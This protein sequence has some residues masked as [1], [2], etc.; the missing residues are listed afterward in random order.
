[1]ITDA[2]KSIVE[3]EDASAA[4]IKKAEAKRSEIISNA[5]IQAD[6][7]RKMG[8]EKVRKYLS[9]QNSQ[10]MQQAHDAAAR[11]EAEIC[12]KIDDEIKQNQQNAQ[13]A[14]DFVV[15]KLN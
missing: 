4:E 3:A 14:T 13:K 9:E 11:E 10:S 15:E 12:G 6:S 7:L 5:E 1:M 8:S 2:I